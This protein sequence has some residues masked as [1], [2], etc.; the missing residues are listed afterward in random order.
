MQGQSEQVA[1]IAFAPLGE[2]YDELVPR[3]QSPSLPIILRT[4]TVKLMHADV[5]IPA[6]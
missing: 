1:S 4:R 3:E 2:A 5:S 6:A